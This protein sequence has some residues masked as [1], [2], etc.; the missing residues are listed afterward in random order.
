MSDSPQWRLNPRVAFSPFDGSA[1]Q[2]WLLELEDQRGGTLRQALSAKLHDVL[3][4]LAR[5]TS[6]QGLI[7]DLRA[8]GW[9]E[10]ALER[11]RV[12][13]FQQAVSERIL[14]AAADENFHAPLQAR[15]PA[16]MGFMLALLGARQVNWMARPWA[17]LYAKPGLMAGALWAVLGQV[18]LIRALLEPRL[19]LPP[20]SAEI[21]IGICI[22]IF[23]VLVHEL[24][25]AAAAWRLG[26][27]K[28]SIG[29]GW[30]V[31][32]PVAWADLSEIWRFPSRHRALVDVA[33]V[34]AQSLIVTF[35]MIGYY[36]SGNAL[37]L[38]AAAAAS[39]SV[40]WNL[41][42]LLRLD[43]FWLLSDLLGVANLRAEGRA[44]FKW[45]WNRLAPIRWQF[46]DA[47]R[48][49]ISDR[50]SAL[51]ALYAMASA[52]FL[53]IVCG[54]AATRFAD[55][56]WTGVPGYYRQL[57]ATRFAEQGLADLTV[58]CGGL[59]WKLILLV[60]L[61]RLLAK[62]LMKCLAWLGRGFG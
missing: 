34:F 10:L 47:L 9:S 45:H 36:F 56:L 19:F 2:Q 38:A 43:G 53:V 25:H 55:A 30:Y 23:V 24:G 1:G 41:N 28:V 3:L 61:G 42:P 33:G 39:L 50:V 16:Y 4:L 5:P 57:V 44:A 14:I 35:L 51:L 59:L 21:L 26:A 40:L 60:F 18:L 15:K 12:V 27:R 6:E 20:T 46:F 7:D 11:L 32:F 29:V 54:L 37:L 52:C 58:M 22:G 17:W 13:L 31:L 49:R 62:S 8:R 48:P